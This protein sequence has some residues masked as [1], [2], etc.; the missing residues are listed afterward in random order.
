M[1]VKMTIL[2]WALKYHKQRWSL[3][4]IGFGKKPP[5]GF[6]W[7]NYQR[8]RADETQLRTWFSD[9]KY[10]SLAVVCGAISGGLAVLDLDSDERCHWWRFW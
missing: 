1:N 3:I 7:K 2:D 4:P 5:R 10:K 6:K 9:G 8:V